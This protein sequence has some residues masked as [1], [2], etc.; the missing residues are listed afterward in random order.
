M[1]NSYLSDILVDMRN[2]KITLN[3][4]ADTIIGDITK[5]MG[6]SFAKVYEKLDEFVTKKEFSE[7]R[8]EVNERFDDVE[9]QIGPQSRRLD[10]LEDKVRQISTKVELDK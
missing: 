4:L 7:F 1:K 5:V 9:V 8:G 2:S 10:R 6:E 3:T